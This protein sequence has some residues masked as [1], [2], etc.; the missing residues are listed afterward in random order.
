[1]ERPLTRRQLA[2]RITSWTLRDEEVQR[3]ADMPK[4][5]QE[6][7]ATS[8]S[9]GHQRSKREASASVSARSQSSR[10]GIIVASPSAEHQRLTK[11]ALATLSA[12]NLAPKRNNIMSSSRV[13]RMLSKISDN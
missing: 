2:N 5:M 11:E 9:A 4:F 3:T 13:E 6:I 7:A 12:G 10:R 8:P 1:M